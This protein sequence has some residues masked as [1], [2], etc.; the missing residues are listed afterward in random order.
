MSMLNL[1]KKLALSLQALTLMF[2]FGAA[3]V[4]A[5][6]PISAG[7]ASAATANCNVTDPSQSST[8][9]QDGAN[10]GQANGTSSNLFG[11]G[12]V[13]QTIA[14][15][16]IFLVGAIAVLFLIIGGLRYVI[17]NG[18]PKAVESAKNTILYAIIGIIIAILS[19]AA[20]Q[21]VI[22]TFSKS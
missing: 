10:C 21:F 16:L 7:V 19:F 2:G 22:S 9:L 4:A 8:P 6:A 1:G 11:N 5:L 3:T 15:T 20:V 17:S 12:G 13:F 14:N 18:D